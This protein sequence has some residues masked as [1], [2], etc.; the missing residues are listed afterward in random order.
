[1]FAIMK[2][3]LGGYEGEDALWK[4]KEVNFF[5]ILT[6]IKAEMEAAGLK[7]FAYYPYLT[8]APSLSNLDLIKQN[9]KPLDVFFAPVKCEAYLWPSEYPDLGQLSWE[10]IDSERHTRI[11]FNDLKTNEIPCPIRLGDGGDDKYAVFLMK[12]LEVYTY[13][14]RVILDFNNLTYRNISTDT[15]IHRS[16]SG[17]LTFAIFKQIDNDTEKSTRYHIDVVAQAKIIP[18]YRALMLK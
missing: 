14:K 15:I 3:G 11:Q 2:H 4:I 6:R 12:D 7:G 10:C 18:P 9:T 1:M 8:T 5:H 13:E 16:L 17:S